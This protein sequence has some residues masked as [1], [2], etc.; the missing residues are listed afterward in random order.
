MLIHHINKTK[1]IQF[2]TF[3]KFLA[4][5]ASFTKPIPLKSILD[6]KMN[7]ASGFFKDKTDG[8]I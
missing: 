7:E 2:I 6:H 4:K 5:N 1:N 3:S 8:K